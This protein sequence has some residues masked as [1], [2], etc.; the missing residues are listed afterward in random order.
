MMSLDQFSIL[1]EGAFGFGKSFYSIDA[2]RA[3]L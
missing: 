2:F 1:M 3:T